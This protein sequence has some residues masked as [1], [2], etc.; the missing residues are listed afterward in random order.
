MLTA[1]TLR[2]GMPLMP[3]RLA[4]ETSP[5]L[6]QHQDNLVDWYPWSDEALRR[7]RD[8]R[9]PIFL[10]IGYSACHWCH[11]MAHE[12]FDDPE[13]AAILNAQFVNVKVDREERPDL[14]AIYMSAVQAMSGQGGWPLSAFLTPEGEPFFGGTYWP[15]RDKMGMPGFIK[16]I[17]TIANAWA[18]NPD[19]VTE[20][21]ASVRAYLRQANEASLDGDALEPTI[22]TDA[23]TA[24][25]TQFDAEHGGFGGA[26]KF[27]QASVLDFLLRHHHRTGDDSALQMVLTTLDR[28]ADGG[29]HDQLGGGFARYAVDRIWLVPHFEKMLYDNG[30]LLSLYLDAWKITG[31]ARYRAVVED[32]A[33]WTL[34]EMTGPEGGFFASLDADSDGHEGTFYV[35]T[36]AEVEAAL[37]GHLTPDEIDLVTLHWGITRGGNFEGKTVLSVVRPIADL[38]EQTGIASDTIAATIARARELLFITREQRTHPARDEKV[39]VSWNA[40]MLKALATAGDALQREDLLAAATRNADFLLTNLRDPDRHLART[41]RNGTLRGQ[42]MLEDHAFLADALIALY[43]ATS[44]IRWLDAASDLVDEVIARFAHD[45]GVGFADTARDHEALI[46]RPR[47]LQ[48]GATPSGNAVM[49]DVLIALGIYR[50]DDTLPAQTEAILRSLATVMREHPLFMGRHLAALTRWLSPCQELVLVGDQTSSAFTSL[51]TSV[52]ARYEP[53]VVQGI[54]SDE[55]QVALRFPM[56]MARPVPHGEAAAYLCEGMTC[57]PPVA[58]AEELVALLDRERRTHHAIT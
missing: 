4:H 25:A 42:G 55:E 16:V 35:W 50:A 10:S 37:V 38:A 49:A 21:A 44:E 3:N 5:Y 17:A 40:L 28:M 23:V 29:I 14:D 34:R 15:P 47:E 20:S 53:L 26:P 43:V 18:S 13:I 36:L 7:A 24:L 48:D 22:T 32:I 54:S 30:Q 45:S 2:E 46:A 12:S 9:K 56:L 31:E 33:A 51:R 41:W 57:L 27:P 52:A 1:C 8:E 19:G 11:V 58:S 39:I 6:L